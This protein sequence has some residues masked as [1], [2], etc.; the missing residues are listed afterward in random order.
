MCE[1]TVFRYV[2]TCEEAVLPF[3]LNRTEL[4]SRYD[5]G[6]ILQLGHLEN[7][8][9]YLSTQYDTILPDELVTMPERE[10]RLLF[11]RVGRRAGVPSGVRAGSNPGGSQAAWVKRYF[12]DKSVDLEDDPAYRS[13][14][15]EYIPST[16]EDNPYLSPLYINRL[17]GLPEDLREAYLRGNWDIFPGQFF[18]EWKSRLITESGVS[19][20]TQNFSHVIPNQEYPDQ[21]LRVCVIDWGYVKPGWVGWFVLLPDGH[22]VLEEEYLFQR[23]QALDVAREIARRTKVR[24]LR[25]IRYIGDYEMNK[26][27]TDS[28]E[29]IRETFARFGV[30]F[31]PADKDRK[32]GWVRFRAWFR[33]APDGKPWLQSLEKNKYFN[34][35]IPMLVLD[36]NDPED[37]ADK[38]ED[39][40]GDGGRYFAMS[41]PFP[42]EAAKIVVYGPHTVG[43]LKQRIRDKMETERKGF[44]GR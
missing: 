25:R 7:V 8:T 41:R 27:Q 42:D 36:D 24:D 17:L 16:V 26:P 29:S 28:G 15:Y 23:T 38:Q 6:S 11:S 13:I 32:N 35:T 37:I 12:V 20:L 1:H 40:A 43:A 18:S 10:M 2:L 39:H 22:A 9:Q 44:Y 14:D 19:K 21:Y 30:S 5:N 3:K 33:A 34:R 4:F 31:Q